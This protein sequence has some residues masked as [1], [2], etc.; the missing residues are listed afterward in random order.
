[1][2]DEIPSL[3]AAKAA[4]MFGSSMGKLTIE[5]R[6]SGWIVLEDGKRVGGTV[7]HPFTNQAA[8]QRYVDAELAGEAETMGRG[9][10]GLSAQC[11]VIRGTDPKVWAKT[12]RIEK[13]FAD[14]DDAR[15]AAHHAAGTTIVLVRMMMAALE[16]EGKIEPCGE[17]D[18]RTVYGLRGPA[19]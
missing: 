1:M 5:Q 18:G 16:A 17:R 14:D 4:A 12:E 6:G 7:R 9:D 13:K 10:V 11:R 19:S 2:D 8:A 3:T 15:W